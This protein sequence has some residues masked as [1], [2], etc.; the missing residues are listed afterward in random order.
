MWSYAQQTGSFHNG[1]FGTIGY[2]GF[3][4]GKNNPSAQ[5]L[6]SIGPVPVGDYMIEGPF[7][8]D[9]GAHGPY[10]FNLVPNVLN[11]MYGRSGFMI[12]GDSIEHAGSASHGCIILSRIAREAIGASTDR[13]LEVT[14]S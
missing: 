14:V 1:S 12:H 4:I 5:S 11:V 10:V 6:V 8:L 13:R 2:S 7:D 3:G 9:G